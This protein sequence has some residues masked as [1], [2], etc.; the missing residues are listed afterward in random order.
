MLAVLTRLEDQG[1]EEGR[2]E[3]REEGRK[4]GRKEASEHLNMLYANLF[5]VGRA[6]DVQR[7]VQD[8]EYLRQLMA[9]FGHP[10]DA[11]KTKSPE[12]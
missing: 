4:E 7:A 6:N 12:A 10:T 9:E 1:R 2:K 3:G 5:K 8:P 11:V